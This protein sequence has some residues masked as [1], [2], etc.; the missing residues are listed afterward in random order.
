MPSDLAHT[1][2]PAPPRAGCVDG[3]VENPTGSGL[4]SLACAGNQVVYRF[5]FGLVLFFAIMIVGSTVSRAWHVGLWSIK[6]ILWIVIT[7][8][9]FFIPNGAPL[10]MGRDRDQPLTH[11]RPAQTFTSCTPRSPGSSAFYS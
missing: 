11:R 5:S 8:G 1:G 7:A 6:T 3:S 10:A 2:F 4:T 9:V